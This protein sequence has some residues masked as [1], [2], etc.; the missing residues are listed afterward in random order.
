MNRLALLLVVGLVAAACGGSSTATDQDIRLVT[1]GAAFQVLDEQPADLVVLDIRTPEEFAGPRLP[2]AVNVDFYD[3]DFA[4]QLDEL[5]K[6]AT[7]VLYCRS[8]NRTS[9]AIPIMREA[10]GGD[11]F[12]LIPS[13]LSILHRH[14]P[15]LWNKMI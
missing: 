5:D 4:D 9:Q 10:G 2:N 14:V 13:F 1:P 15:N 12:L 3:A 8:G 7:Y 6:T 11:F